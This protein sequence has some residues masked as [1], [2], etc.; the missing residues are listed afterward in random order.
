MEIFYAVC[1]GA[2]LLVGPAI[3]AV[4]ALARTSGVSQQKQRI[5]ELERRIADLVEQ[6]Q[7][8]RDAIAR[9][10]SGE[11]VDAA[12]T[13]AAPPAEP[14]AAPRGTAHTPAWSA[15]AAPGP[16]SP[17]AMPADV[18][19][20]S[21][22]AARAAPTPS[23]PRPPPPSS[24]QWERWI[25]VSFTA[26]LGGGTLALAGLLFF[27][28]AVKT[29][30]LSPTIRVVLGTIVGVACIAGGEALRS[31]RA[32]AS[33][34]ALAG[35]G[36]V[37]LYAAFWAAYV[38]YR[39]IPLEVAAP[40][41]LLVTA[42]GCVIAVRH[43]T[44]FVA[45]LALAGGFATPL[46]L[47][48]GHDRPVGLFSYVLLLDA[49]FLW[50]AWRRRW[51]VLGLLA[52]AG[53]SLLQTLW[54]AKNLGPGGLPLALGIVG[55]FA[56]VFALSGRL[57]PAEGRWV[58][59]LGQ[60]GGVLI[61]FAFALHFAVNAR[62]GSHF[63]PIGALLV[64]LTA[65]AGWIGRESKTPFVPLGAAAGSLAVSG[66]WLLVRGS[67]ADLAWEAAL[68][69][70]LIAAVLHAFVEI[71]QRRAGL[72][73][74]MPAA[75]SSSC[76]FLFLFGIAAFGRGGASYW[77]WIAAWSALAGI[78]LR[79]A[80]VPGFA[81]VQ[82]VAAVGL[83]LALTFLHGGHAGD[84]RFP[85]P[86]VHHGVVLAFATSLLGISLMRREPAT[87]M[88][89]H[90]AAALLSVVLSVGGTT[91]VAW[92]ELDP[93]WLLPG[94]ALVLGFIAV[95]GGTRAKSGTWILVAALTT[96]F[97]HHGWTDRILGDPGRVAAGLAVQ[98]LAVLLFTAWPFAVPG[99]F[100]ESRAAWLTSALAGPLWFLLLRRLFLARFG[101]AA[102]GLLP[103]G[104]GAVS[105]VAA[106]LA[107][108][109]WP[110]GSAMR[111]TAL[112]PQLAAALGFVSIAIP[113]QLRNEW[114]TIAWA[115][116]A[117]AAIWLWRRFDQPA[118]KYFGLALLAAVT[119]RLVGNAA[120]LDY[121]PRGSA[122]IVNWL[123]YTYLL[124]AAALLAAS[125][126]LRAPG[127][128]PLRSWETPFHPKG[129]PLFAS[130]CGLAAIVVVFALLNLEI[131]DWYST[132]DRLVVSFE[133]MPARDVATSIVW[134]IYSGL[135]LA[136]GIART[137]R[138]LRAVALGFFVLTVAKVYFY[139]LSSLRDLYR[140]ASTAGLALVLIL[141]SFGYQRF[142]FRKSAGGP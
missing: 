140:V 90:H 100:R 15:G 51:A 64:L 73:S 65:A 122:R 58:W 6:V 41:M 56:G 125:A 88:A 130:A 134:A 7:M 46:L 102:I 8:L 142:V 114:I 10:V 84:A 26:I 127:A 96:V 108:R 1:L 40:L 86:L 123:L 31:R 9:R 112:A 47:S 69:G 126:L 63:L 59:L 76:G 52:L 55:L 45:I 106:R 141:V 27:H 99:A 118:L 39:L 120:V 79:Q 129:A 105:L 53:T 17:P 68:I 77:P 16:S 54:I 137:S 138:W 2:A 5:A 11:Y 135:L 62:L 92:R 128:P 109:A 95:L 44:L 81:P 22:T 89:G 139:D 80:G 75:L 61:P 36:L 33:A 107:V 29:G 50:I 103:L 57:A 3:L 34:N 13:P 74:P 117:V 25:G 19:P 12:A 124:P 72:E 14:P 32:P 38:L 97:A 119:V 30:L 93:S 49:G 18:P 111:G 98:A 91:S 78:L 60:A 101:D 24:F 42:A 28:Y 37:I 85:E 132:G 4:I 115:L 20:P 23:G 48:A 131:A 121:Y 66:V 43:E 35:G 71:D 94:A 110:R 67:V 133:R 83:G 116:E 21:T 113:M 104:L 82:S 70:V 87:R 136:I